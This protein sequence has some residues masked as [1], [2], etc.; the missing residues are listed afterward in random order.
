MLDRFKVPSEDELRVP[1]D[2]LRE[3][4]AALFEKVGVSRRTRPR[5]L[6]CW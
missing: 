1:E 6:T 5:A 2:S 3:T 4:V